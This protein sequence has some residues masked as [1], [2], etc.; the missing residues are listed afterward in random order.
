VL[1]AVGASNVVVHASHE[2]CGMAALCAATYPERTRALA[3]FHPQVRGPGSADRA[4][5]EAMGDFRERW[6]TQDFSDR[7][8]REGCPSLLEREGPALVR[9]LAACRGLAGGCVC[10]QP[11][12]ARDRSGSKATPSP[13]PGVQ[14]PGAHPVGAVWVILPSGVFE[15]E[16]PDEFHHFVS[17]ASSAVT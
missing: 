2:G 11:R 13:D 4:T 16:V 3:L 1:D 6:G 10:A 5:Q 15:D 12:V 14:A 17:Y 9:E 8:L 7:L